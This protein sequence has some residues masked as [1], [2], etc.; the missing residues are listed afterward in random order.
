MRALDLR[1][2]TVMAATYDAVARRVVDQLVAAIET[3]NAGTWTMP[4]HRL[5]NARHLS[6]INATTSTGY[7]GG[8]V[9][10]LALEGIERGYA[11]ARWA[12]Y[13]QW[14]GQDA[15]V[16]RGE[17]ATQL[18]RWVTKT[19]DT[20]AGDGEGE[21]RQR[22]IPMVFHVFNADQCDHPDT[23]DE[24]ATIE[25]EPEGSDVDAWLSAIGADVV[26]GGDR[27]FY[28]PTADRITLPPRTSFASDG[29]FWSTSIHEHVHW[30]G[31]RTRL[32][33]D[34][35]TNNDPAQYALE[36]LTAELGAAIICAH[37]GIEPTPRASHAAYLAHWLEQLNAEPRTLFRTASTAQTAADH[38][39]EL[40][41]TPATTSH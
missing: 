24:T 40:A 36:E 4:W 28:D 32:N 13:K 25:A 16:R 19:T 27:A 1:R 34:T 26:V 15:Q 29:D 17:K 30:S 20:D 10:A 6:P 35:L 23:T 3:D 12:T 9:L 38:L 41:T 14:A 31:H 11:S 18:I 5:G 2:E 39:H 22:M 7:K 8:N 33:R 37:H 21:K